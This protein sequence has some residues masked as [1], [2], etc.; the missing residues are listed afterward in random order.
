MSLAMV[1]I[2]LVQLFISVIKT[3]FTIKTGQ[4][5]DAQ[6]ILGYYKHL[7][8]LPQQ[9]FDTMRVGEIISRIND[10]VK[11]RIFLNDVSINFLVNIFIVF[12][13]FLL[14]FTYYWKLA[15]IMLAVIPFY[16]LIYAVTNKLNKKAQRK[17]ME[18]AAEI[19]SQ[20]V[21]S[22][23]SVGTIKRFGLEEHA[24]EKTETRFITLL[25]TVYTSSMNSVFS[26]T[27][28][29]FISRLLAIILLS[30][31]AN[32]VLHN[33]ITPGELLSFYTLIGYFTGP[34]TSLI[35]MNKTVQDAVIAADRL[36]EIMDLE[37][38]NEHN[39]IVLTPDKLGDLR[40]EKVSFRY[41]T[42]TKVFESLSLNIS[43][44]KFTAIVG[45][46]GSGKSTLMSLLQNIYPIQ[47]GN[48]YI[49]KYDLK[50]IT[51]SSLRSI[52]SVVP[53]QIDLFAGNVND[54]IAIGDQN[55]DMQRIVDIAEQLG[56]IEFIESL[57]KGFQTYLG[58]NG[59]TLSGGQRQRIAIARALYRNP[60][61]LILD[62]AT[63]SLDSTS[64]KYVQ[65][66]INFLKSNHKTVILITHR[67]STILNADKIIVLDEG[68]VAEEGTHYELIES[69]SVYY[70]LWEQ[71]NP[72]NSQLSSLLQQKKPG[73]IVQPD[74]IS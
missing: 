57:P 70:N 30:V 22:L 58:E 9:F 63:S 44:G 1:V 26:G 36:F 12:F 29:E 65:Q 35:G 2:L 66:A 25:Q 31:G 71:Q 38:E 3:V 54:N 13:S 4:L 55:P 15:L 41:G 45:E 23:N 33:Q 6:L 39:Q 27:S 17:L 73:I 67:L 47:K 69:Q 40:F 46:S 5:I 37:R 14:M 49:G 59:T 18:N 74:F 48:I 43:K 10:A 8:K 24:N 20:L 53:Q 50:Y 28:S 56:I 60:E 32:Y 52:V 42:R 19:E 62:E 34:V 16:L 64:E 61:I 21:E 7:L 72:L 11:I 51:N 68:L